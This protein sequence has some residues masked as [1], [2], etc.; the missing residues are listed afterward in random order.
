MA[1]AQLSEKYFGSVAKYYI[2]A[3]IDKV[4]TL[5]S[6]HFP[7]TSVPEELVKIITNIG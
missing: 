2:K 3:S 4:I 6:G 7:L 1:E 5:K